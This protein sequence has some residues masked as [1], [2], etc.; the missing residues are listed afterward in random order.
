MPKITQNNCEHL[1][2]FMD[3]LWQ[4]YPQRRYSMSRISDDRQG[5]L[6]AL[7]PK[8]PFL[9]ARAAMELDSLILAQQPS[10]D[11][12]RQLASLLQGSTIV[13]SGQRQSL[14][15]PATVDLVGRAIVSQG[16]QVLT[17]TDLA[18]AA[19]RIANDLAGAEQ[20]PQRQLIEK[21][22]EFCVALSREA[23]AYLFSETDA[24]ASHPFRR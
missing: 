4:T 7:D 23:S 17:I 18:D 13:T 16:N 12:V 21:M 9:A 6:R 22:R 10:L 19:A 14:M 15:D 20:D 1:P 2:N 8:L 5:I 3:E 24:E 11:S